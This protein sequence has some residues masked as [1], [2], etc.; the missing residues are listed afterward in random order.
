MTD[1]NLAIQIFDAIE[2]DLGLENKIM[3]DLGSGT[4]ML[5]IAGIIY[6][7]EKCISVELDEDAI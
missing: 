2:E 4:G 1:R 7:L 5:S 3:A 6:G